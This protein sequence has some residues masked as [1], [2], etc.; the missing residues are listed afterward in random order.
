MSPYSLC[1]A[2][3]QRPVG[4]GKKSQVV[5][6]IEDS[7]IGDACC[8]SVSQPKGGVPLSDRGKEQGRMASCVGQ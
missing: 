1:S 4:S 3:D 6:D 2:L 7:V 5:H 8:E